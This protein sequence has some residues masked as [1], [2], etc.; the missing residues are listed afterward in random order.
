MFSKIFIWFKGRYVN[1]QHREAD[2]TKTHT[3]DFCL[4]QETISWEQVELNCTLKQPPK[5]TSVLCVN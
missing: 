1:K 4:G 2:I 5:G 3:S